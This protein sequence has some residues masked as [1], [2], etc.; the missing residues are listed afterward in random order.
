MGASIFDLSHKMSAAMGAKSAPINRNPVC[1]GH[2]RKSAL[3]PSSLDAPM[4]ATAHHILGVRGVSRRGLGQGKSY[5][6]Q[7]YLLLDVQA[8]TNRSGAK[9]FLAVWQSM[10][11][12]CGEPFTFCQ[13]IRRQKFQPNRRRCDAHR[14]P[15]KR[16]QWRAP[17][18]A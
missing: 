16:V 10:C 17:V 13:S 14:A 3:I 4:G 12:D 7:T 6:G 5:D 11:A 9:T 2:E 15:G 18:Q 1:D 8:C